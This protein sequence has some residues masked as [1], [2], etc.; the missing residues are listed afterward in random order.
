MAGAFRGIGI[1]IAFIILY[2]LND[3]YN[4]IK[5]FAIQRLSCEE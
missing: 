4:N 1:N 2:S 5:S 3:I